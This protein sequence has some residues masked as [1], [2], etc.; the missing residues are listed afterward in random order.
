MT[1]HF[2]SI[3]PSWGNELVTDFQKGQDLKVLIYSDYFRDSLDDSKKQHDA[4]C[5]SNND[6]STG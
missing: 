2:V 4:S 6:S 5:N 3:E 1:E